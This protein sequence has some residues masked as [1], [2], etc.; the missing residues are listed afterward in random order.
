MP[1]DQNTAT[2]V[3]LGTEFRSASGRSSVYSDGTDEECPRPT[4]Q[5]PHEHDAQVVSP[6]ERNELQRTTG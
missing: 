4:N 3:V 2:T 5:K 6:D 1:P